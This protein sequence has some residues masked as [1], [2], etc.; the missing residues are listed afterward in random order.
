MEQFLAL[1]QT[2]E[3]QWLAIVAI[4]MEGD[5]GPWFQMFQKMNL[6]PNWQALVQ[7]VEA[8]FGPSPFDSPRAAL[9]K[10]QQIDSV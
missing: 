1:Y 6:L 4:H 10:L 3:P 8:R 5:A 9:F 7:A 2:P